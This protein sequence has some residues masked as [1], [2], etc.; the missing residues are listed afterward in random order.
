[1]MESKKREANEMDDGLNRV[2]WYRGLNKQ[3][4]PNGSKLGMMAMKQTMRHEHEEQRMRLM[5]L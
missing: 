5:G 1:M 2:G 4:E 3:S